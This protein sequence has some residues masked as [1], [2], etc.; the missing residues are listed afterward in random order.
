[1]IKHLHHNE[2]DRLKWD[3]CINNAPNALIY[4]Y[5]FYLDNIAPGWNA[6]ILGDYTA[7]M[8]LPVRKKWGFTYLY[9]PAFTQQL[10]IFSSE[11]I[12]E[13]TT[14]NFITVLKQHY[15]FA[16][17]TLNYANG[18]NHLNEKVSIRNNYIKL[19]NQTEVGFEH[20]DNYLQY[21]FRRA[22]K[23][24]LSYEPIT[25]YQIVINL[26]HTLYGK[27]LPEF[28]NKDYNNFSKICN[29]L[30]SQQCVIT[31]VCL[32]DNQIV[33]A[34]L[35]VKSEKRLYN[36]ISCLTQEG[37]ILK[38]NYFM[39]GKL[40]EEFSGT[41]YSLD[42]EGSD[43]PGIKY[44]YEKMSTINQPY[45]FIKWNNLPTLFKWLKNGLD[46]IQKN[47]IPL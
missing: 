31:R 1:M 28:K 36:L 19:L 38:A 37:K 3:N 47:L 24:N 39:F 34:I 29:H 20:S 45:Y 14:N 6:L 25:D 43:H 27:K 18:C 12:N 10:G 32:H 17:I 30:N 15:R 44:F 5:S 4:A 41:D 23:N 42:F 46:N 7:V 26:Y 22:N 40:I 35:L 8:P 21:R 16:E 11:E 33:A 9:Q 13:K 2:I